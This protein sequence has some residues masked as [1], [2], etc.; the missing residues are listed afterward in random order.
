MP[1]RAT[2]RKSDKVKP[3]V[4]I[5]GNLRACVASLVDIIAR[6]DRRIASLEKRDAR[7]LIGFTSV[8]ASQDVPE[9]TDDDI[10]ESGPVGTAC[11]EL[12]VLPLPSLHVQAMAR[13]SL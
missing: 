8:E 7:R 12:P 6:Q 5:T 4:V 11:D 10:W 2:K 13:L 3:N 1:R 9:P